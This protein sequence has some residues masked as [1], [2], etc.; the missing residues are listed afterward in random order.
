MNASGKSLRLKLAIV[1]AVLSFAQVLSAA[2]PA[3]NWIAAPNVA[4]DGRTYFRQPA[5]IAQ[6]VTSARLVA[7]ADMA[8]VDFYLDGK[9]LFELDPFDPLLKL[10]LTQ[11]FSRG[12]HLLAVRCRH[13][14]SSAMFFMRVQ[15]ELADGTQKTLV[16]DN[17][18][19]CSAKLAEGWM[20]L[21]FNADGWSE[22]VSQSAVDE[23]LLISDQRRIDLAATEN[24]EQWRQASGATEGANP[25]TF[26]ITP[27][28]RIELVRSA[29]AGEDSWISLIFD[30]QGR[31]ILS[32]EQQG[33]LRLTLTRDGSAAQSVERINDDLKE[34]RGMVFLGR[35]LYVNA[36]NSKGMYR[37]RGDLAG[38]LDK[39]EL[40]FATAGGIGHGRNDLAVGPDGKIYSIHGDDVQTLKTATDYTLG[41]RES[42]PEHSPG[43]GH[44]IRL[45]PTNG[46]TETLVTGLRNPFGIAFNPAGDMFTYDADA[47]FDM[48]TPWYRPT[49]VNHL[50]LGSDF[51][52]RGVTGQWPPY[53]PD[54]PDNA[55]GNLDIGKGS[56]TAVMFGTRS[57]FPRRYREALFMLDWAYGRILIVHCLPHGA[58]Y[59]CEAETFLKGTAAECDRYGFRSG[60]FDVPG[61]RR[62]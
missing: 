55:P 9:I 11:E 25:A 31:A 3:P 8:G 17:S 5:E 19:R 61:D 59:R 6:Q 30:P 10:D 48:G 22:S 16:T 20:N 39:P 14:S 2:E 27:G 24:Y 7:A 28:F 41:F 32:Q 12:K 62:T 15:L 42:R 38:N 36:N 52:W 45:D 58:G 33:L 53:F 23:R 21:D 60:R 40:L 26:S 50:T 18:W 35:D 47:E 56:P 34:V 13:A 43:Q 44:L 4:A 29:A 54:H 1:L 51:G 57:D 37:L 49:R 46:K